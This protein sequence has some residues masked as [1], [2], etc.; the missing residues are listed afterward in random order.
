MQ[1]SWD[2]LRNFVLIAV[3]L[4]ILLGSCATIRKGTQAEPA[5]KTVL[6]FTIASKGLPEGGMWKCT[7]AFADINNDGYLDMA[8]VRRLGKGARVWLGDGGT[9]WTDSS[10]GLTYDITCGGG[11]AFGD[12]NNDNFL[13]LVVADH[14]T[15]VYTFL[16][17]G[18][19]NWTRTDTVLRPPAPEG[20]TPDEEGFYIGTEDLALGDVNE[21]GFLDLVLAASDMGGFSVYLGDGSGK[22]WQAVPAGDGL[23][24]GND[25]EPGD[26]ENGGWAN[27]VMLADVN[28]DG[29][30]D[31]VASYYRGPGVWLGDGKAHWVNSSEGLPRP[32]IGGLFRGIAVGDVNEDGLPDLA[33]ANDVNGPEVYLQA[34]DGSWKSTADV[35]P[36]L[37]AGAV[38]VALGDLDGDGH[39][40]LL[41]GGRPSEG[42]G[43]AY[44]LYV[45]LGDGK[46]GWQELHNTH[47]PSTGLSVT[48]GITIADV[49]ND[50]V[51]D[52]SAATGGT[53]SSKVREGPGS[54]VKSTSKLPRLQVWLTHLKK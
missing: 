16:G 2:G 7:P 14:C 46:G 48:W 20:I 18:K 4:P 5:S 15:G 19:G 17:D 50:G 49:N 38:T 1:D 30:L 32:I 8:A 11:V 26:E 22:N 54:K 35:L 33:V 13:D 3:V 9:S 10:A 21:D 52:F 34:Q 6:Q 37:E 44:G 29:H 39:L 24:S 53:S 27:Q 36:S 23:P 25:P 31:V 12:I 51:P 41:V 42:Y 45:L 40:D 47:L 43:D 28:R